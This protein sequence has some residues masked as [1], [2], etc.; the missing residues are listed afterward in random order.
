MACPQCSIEWFCSILLA[1][2][3][4]IDFF[5]KDETVL[6]RR[7]EREPIALYEVCITE[8]HLYGERPPAKVQQ[9]ARPAC[10]PGGKPQLPLNNPSHKWK[11]D[12][13]VRFPGS[14]GANEH[15]QAAKFQRLIANR[16]IVSNGQFFQCAHRVGSVLHWP[17]N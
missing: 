8:L 2:A 17:Q 12:D 5:P 13:E 9:T 11:D 7:H 15:I 1:L 10:Y 14:V 16:L 4:P 3:R 6:F